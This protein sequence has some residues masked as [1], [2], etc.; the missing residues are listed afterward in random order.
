MYNRE[1]V[2]HFR[3]SYNEQLHL[4]RLNDGRLIEF[5]AIQH[6]KDKENQ[7]GRPRDFYGWDEITQFT[8]AIYRFVNAWLRSTVPG[9]R[10]RVVATGNPPTSSDGEWVIRYW[11]PW[12]DVQHPNPAKPGEL[13]WF[14]RLNDEDVEVADGSIIRHKGETIVPRSRTFIPARLSDNPILAQTGYGAILQSMPEPLR[15]QMLYGDFS[16]GVGDD[17]WQVIPTAWIRAAMARWTETPPPGVSLTCIGAD[18]SRGGADLTVAAPRWG[19]WFARMTSY[20]GT[21]TDTGPKAAQL[22]LRHH[23]G[24][25]KVNF[26]VIGVGSSA[27]DAARGIIGGLAVPVNVSEATTYTDRSGAY[28]M[29]NV[30]AAMYWRM[31]DALDPERGENLSLPPD[32]ELLAD[33]CAA[34][35]QVRANGIILEPK[36]DTRE[37]TGRSPDKGDACCL[38]LWDGGGIIPR[39]LVWA[40]EEVR[41]PASP[42]TIQSVMN[43]LGDEVWEP[44]GGQ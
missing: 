8:E 17:I 33:L 6:D 43:D 10:K 38:S 1:A 16:I 18:I 13:R 7:R 3:D 12:L 40:G 11:G 27:Y 5:G 29:V 44:L 34:R 35:F 41:Q 39:A 28:R 26:D 22:I 31:R 24:R 25:A 20:K 37:R 42:D 19:H 30:R 15:S 2:A 14:A 4:W 21:V 23:D 36:D 9:Q 32:P